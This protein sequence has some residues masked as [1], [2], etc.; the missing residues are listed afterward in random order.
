MKEGEREGGRKEVGGRKMGRGKGERLMGEEEEG[1]GGKK[2]RKFLSVICLYFSS[3]EGMQ[4]VKDK[5]KPF[6]WTYTTDYM[7]SLS[8]ISGGTLEV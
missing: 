8:N 6:D 1:Q 7:G 5:M 2:A 4:K 3:A